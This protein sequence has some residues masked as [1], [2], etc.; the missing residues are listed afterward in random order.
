MS[1]EKAYQFFRLVERMRKAQKEYFKYRTSNI[2][3]D[4]KRL[5]K[6]VD[7]E[8]SRVNNLLLDKQQPKLFNEQ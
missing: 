6:E 7:D 2:L 8:I 3:N 5:E 1:K 4:S